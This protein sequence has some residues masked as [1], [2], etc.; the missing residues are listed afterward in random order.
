M[1]LKFNL[2]RKSRFCM[3]LVEKL[4][5]LGKG[6]TDFDPKTRFK[7]VIEFCFGVCRKY[8]MPAQNSSKLASKLR[9]SEKL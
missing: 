6:L 4:Q 8:V 9:E 2:E 3:I 7:N 5:Y 1:S